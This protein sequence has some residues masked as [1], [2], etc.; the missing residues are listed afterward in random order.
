MPVK[1]GSASGSSWSVI[2]I[3]SALD[4]MKQV[5]RLRKARMLKLHI[6]LKHYGRFMRDWHAPILHGSRL[7]K[8]S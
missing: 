4:C 3:R 7:F 1:T 6:S 5:L 2:W 8:N